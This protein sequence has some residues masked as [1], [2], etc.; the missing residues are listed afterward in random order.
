MSGALFE[1]MNVDGMKT[2]RIQFFCPKFYAFE[3]ASGGN[4]FL[5]ESDPEAVWCAGKATFAFAD[6]V[7]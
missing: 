4:L 6:L 7:A 1:Y 3:T 2:F 5:H